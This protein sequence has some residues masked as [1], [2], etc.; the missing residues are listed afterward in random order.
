MVD[1]N[2]G[3]VPTLSVREG[4]DLRTAIDNLSR[5]VAAGG[6]IVYGTDLGNAG[7]QPGIDPLET[8]AMSAAGMSARDI[9]RSATVT[10]AEQMGLDDRGVLEIGRRADIVGIR[11]GGA[12]DV[13]ALTAVEVVIRSGRVA[14]S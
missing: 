8:R 14:R 5:F 4:R 3:I 13:G 12:L 11:T 10:A 7:P 6:R 1:A 2:M 9:I